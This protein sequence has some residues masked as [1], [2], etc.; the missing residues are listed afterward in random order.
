MDTLT[1]EIRNPKVRALLD[2]LAELELIAIVPDKSA[3]REEWKN[4][5]GTLPEAA[6][7]S[8]EDIPGEGEDLRADSQV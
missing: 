6:D 7:V 2:T 4:L 3:W 1:I 5:A 8:E